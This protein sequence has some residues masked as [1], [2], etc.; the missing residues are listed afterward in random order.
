MAVT[1]AHPVARV[2][3]AP[4][5]MAAPAA[6][7]AP[8]ATTGNPNAEAIVS[9]SVLDLSA[10]LIVYGTEVRREADVHALP[11]GRYGLMELGPNYELSEP[12]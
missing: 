11:F 10:R 8:T 12:L 2:V 5:E 3:T 6:A 4:A 9:L 7:T 1:A